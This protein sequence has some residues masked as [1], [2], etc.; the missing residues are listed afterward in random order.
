MEII[1]EGYS[2]IKVI[3]SGGEPRHFRQEVS[4]V[5]ESIRAE[6]SEKDIDIQ[7]WASTIRSHGQL[8]E[9]HPFLRMCND[10]GLQESHPLR[11]LGSWA[12]GFGNPWIVIH[13]IEI[14]N[15][16]Q[17]SVFERRQFDPDC[18]D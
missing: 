5:L 18:R 1:V 9:D 3:S 4:K 2:F 16:Q 8:P 15:D 6:C 10:L 13:Q 17:S 7:T 11:T 12:F 14:K